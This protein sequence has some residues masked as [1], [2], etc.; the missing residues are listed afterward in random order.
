MADAVVSEH[1]T[2]TYQHTPENGV[3]TVAEQPLSTFSVDVDTASYANVRRMLNQGMT[4]PKDAIRLE[5]MIN[6]FSYEYPQPKDDAPFYVD[7]SIAES[8]LD[9]NKHILRVALSG[10]QVSNAQRKASN[11]VFLLDVSGSMSADNKLPLLKRALTMLSKQLDARD[12]VAIV[13]YAGASGVVLEPTSGDDTL[14]IVQALE[15]LQAGGSTNGASGIQLAY[16]MAQ[17]A[18]KKDGINR[19]LLATDGDF[20]V[21]TTDH[22]A[23]MGLIEKQ[24]ETGVTLSVLGFG[25]GNY[26]DHLTE[27]LANK[28]NGNAAYID[29]INEARKVLVEQLTGTLQVIAKDVKIQV[30]FNPAVVHEYRLIG[31]ENRQLNKE[32]FNNDKVDAGEIGAGHTVTALYELTLKSAEQYS[33]DELRYQTAADEKDNGDE[34]ALVKLRY[35]NP[36]GESSSKIERIVSLSQIRGF[37]DTD[38]AFKFAHSVAG[39]GQL[40]RGS[41]FVSNKDA[42]AL[43]SN[44]KAAKGQDEHGYRA[45]FIRLMETW[46][47]LQ[48]PVTNKVGAKN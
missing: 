12:S 10:K 11:L 45:E 19:V 36:Q 15:K 26:N 27:Q 42:K 37:A 38:N 32:D 5:E 43:I 25:S 1:N 20:N 41:K 2:E 44:A 31:Y 28:G 22:E 40:M 4:P 16:Q 6:Y 29:N 18:F 13:V 33:V 21:G 47:L 34:V 30:E 39:L 3:W 48:S 23:L 14:S 24:R 35:K 7:T 17:K 46:L 9:N 8:P